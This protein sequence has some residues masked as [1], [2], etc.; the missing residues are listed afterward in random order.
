[1]QKSVSGAASTK[2]KQLCADAER[3]QSGAGADSV[4]DVAGKAKSI[5]SNPVGQ[6]LGDD[7]GNI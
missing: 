2:Y 1:M 4:S 3:K 7:S 6:I 5:A